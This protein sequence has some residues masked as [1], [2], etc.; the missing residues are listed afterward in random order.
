[1]DLGS[2]TW[3]NPTDKPV[4]IKLFV[5]PGQHQTYEVAPKGSASIPSQFTNAIHQCRNGQVVGGAA[6]QLVREDQKETLHPTLAPPTD[7]PADTA[8][9]K[10]AVA[11]AETAADKPPE[12]PNRR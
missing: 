8:A 3:K 1:M 2:T 11:P 10:A 6:P 12:K 4:K 9:D 5:S 7:K